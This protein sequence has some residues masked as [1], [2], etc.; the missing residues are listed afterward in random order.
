MPRRHLHPD[1]QPFPALGERHRHGRTADQ[2][3]G[4]GDVG[5][6]PRTGLPAVYEQGLRFVPMRGDR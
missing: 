1:R 6:V 4:R 5:G 3:E 2:T